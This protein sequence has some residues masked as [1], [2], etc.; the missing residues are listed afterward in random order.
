M[1][2]SHTSTSKFL[3]LVLRHKPDAIGL[4][5][6]A[7]GW[8]DVEELIACA[9]RNGNKL[10]MDLLLEIVA[11][12]DKKRF[13]FNADESRIR[14]NQGHSIEVDLRLQP[15]TPPDVLYHGTATRNIESI[16]EQGLIRGRRHH[17]HLS[18]E[19]ETA[20]K[21][22]MRYGVPVI[23]VV[24]AARMHAEGFVFFVSENGVWLTEHV[25][26]QFI[27]F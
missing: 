2:Q 19:Q 6:D 1:P 4:R 15:T 26:T 16:R 11:T 7:Q 12:S 3:S 5:L 13:S 24:D 27:E 10:T 18:L 8:A 14:A 21:V 22:G 17:V 20:R 25:P 23:L 9:N